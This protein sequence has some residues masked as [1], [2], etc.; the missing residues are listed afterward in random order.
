VNEAATKEDNARWE[1]A[2]RA[3]ATVAMLTDAHADVDQNCHNLR[4]VVCIIAD[5]RR[6]AQRLED[7]IRALEAE[8]DELAA[9]AGQLVMC[10][11]KQLPSQW[12]KQAFPRSLAMATH[13]QR[14]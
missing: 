10:P 1:H 6:A 4:C 14:N 3:Q 7:R 8:K 13:L 9:N 5:H 11:S 2:M 12:H